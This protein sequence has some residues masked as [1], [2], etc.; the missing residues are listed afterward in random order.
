MESNKDFNHYEIRANVTEDQ[1]SKI[2]DFMN[3]IGDEGGGLVQLPAGRLT[4]KGNLHIPE[5]TSLKGVWNGPHQG[6]VA[7]GTVL[8][9]FAG[10]D[11]ENDKPFIQMNPNS[12]LDGVTI[13]YPEQSI[14]DI[15]PYPWTI[16]GIG[17]HNT[18][19]NVTLTNS[20]NGISMGSCPNE[21]HSIRNVFGCVLRRGIYVNKT[22]DIGRI[23]NVHFNPHYWSRSGHEGSYSD[24]K[25]VKKNLDLSIGAEMQ[26]N[27]EAFIFGRTDW[28]Y[29]LNTF[30]F[31][32]RIGYKF[33]ETE[34]G[35]CNGNF[36]GIGSDASQYCL[37]AEQTQSPGLLISNAEFVCLPLGEVDMERIGVVTSPDFS[38]T[39][40]ISNSAFWGD[41][42][43]IV[44]IAGNGFVSIS[45]S[46][47]QGWK[48]EDNPAINVKE[49]RFSVNNT[50]FKGFGP[51]IYLNEKVSYASINHNFAI[52]GVFIMNKSKKEMNI[53]GNEMQ[54]IEK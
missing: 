52:G 46:N 16:E 18:I 13:L 28:E 11:N 14:N 42:T 36:L 54:Y 39:I 33:I 30:V 19:D 49:G 25:S 22:T 43:K 32:A 2:Q 8:L 50:F 47:M 12:S 38:G 27:L 41:F 53:N 15:K 26:K 35:A 17:M 51:H 10:R 29:V 20:Y 45:Q 44:E 48:H 31:G 1:T 9:A 4:I 7:K 34:A 6:L 3:T 24:L 21:L 40:Q 5:G 37:L 23:E